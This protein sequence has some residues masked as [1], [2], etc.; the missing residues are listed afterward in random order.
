MRE[1]KLESE[2][3]GAP[4]GGRSDLLLEQLGAVVVKGVRVRAGVRSGSPRSAPR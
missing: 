2:E 1:S 4:G 3:K